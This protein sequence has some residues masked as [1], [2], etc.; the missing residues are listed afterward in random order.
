ML[1]THDRFVNN[2]LLKFI[3]RP[4]YENSCSI[5]SLTA[6]FNY[7]FAEKIGIKTSNELA[8]IAAN[9]PAK[10]VTGAGNKTVME[11]FNKLC[12]HYGVNGNCS[13]YL[14][15]KEV[16]DW[17]NNP[18]L[19]SKLK[20][21]IKSNNT[22]LIYHLKNHY[23][24]V[25]GYFEHSENPDDAYNDEASLQRWIVLGEHSDYNPISKITQRALK[26]VLSEDKYNLIMESV[27]RTPIWSRIW[28]SI[29]HDLMKSPNHCVLCFSNIS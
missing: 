11:W 29:R 18:N 12:T 27:G 9:K 16:E 20:K 13:Y 2:E 26:A 3:S 10:D 14:R 8:V 25:V 19:I 1:R 28:R 6:V 15:R 24:I 7:L 22:A 17:D 23:N 21:D 4:Q 5:T